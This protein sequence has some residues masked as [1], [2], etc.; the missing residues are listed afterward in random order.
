M[1]A[2]RPV[3]SNDRFNLYVLRSESPGEEP[4][5]VPG[6]EYLDLSEAMGSRSYGYILVHLFP[7]M[8]E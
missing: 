2:L 3:P 6:R 8:S 1:A 7:N 5:S 4:Y